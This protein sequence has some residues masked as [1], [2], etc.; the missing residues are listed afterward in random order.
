MQSFDNGHQLVGFHFLD[1]AGAHVV[2]DLDER[3]TLVF[4]VDEPPENFARAVRK[5]LKQ[6][7]DFGSMQA[8]QQLPT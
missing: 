8:G 4:G 3:L 7:A 1:E 2:V 6:V 5:G